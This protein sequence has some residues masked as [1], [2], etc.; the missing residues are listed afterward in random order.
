MNSM[1]VTHDDSYIC[2][3]A[4]FKIPLLAQGFPG[5]L[6][7]LFHIIVSSWV[8]EVPFRNSRVDWKISEVTNSYNGRYTIDLENFVVKN[9]T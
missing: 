2:L 9:V 8:I 4:F 3:S 1:A 6:T 7:M 5:L